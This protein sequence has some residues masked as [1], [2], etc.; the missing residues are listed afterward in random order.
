[1]NRIAN[2]FSQV[3]TNF[4][5]YYFGMQALRV[6]GRPVAYGPR[7]WPALVDVV[8]PIYIGMLKP[9]TTAANP[10][11]SALHRPA[12]VNQPNGMVYQQ[13]MNYNGDPNFC[14]SVPPQSTGRRPPIAN[15][16]AIGSSF[17]TP[18]LENGEL[19]LS[20]RL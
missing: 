19:D 6:T 17:G 7:T 4:N 8:G 2:V 10:R 3:N 12:M 9:T 1:M 15:V 18:G 5:L 16:F 14:T 11:S 13:R 20:I